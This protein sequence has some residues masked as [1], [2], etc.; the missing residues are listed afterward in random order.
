MN[1]ITPTPEQIANWSFFL[2]L[3]AGILLTLV[4]TWLFSEYGIDWIVARWK[5]RR[6]ATVIDFTE[7]RR[8]NAIAVRWQR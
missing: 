5:G 7:R 1:V 4:L 6:S 8:L 2:G 3:L